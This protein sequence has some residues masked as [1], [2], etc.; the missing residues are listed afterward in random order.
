[1][2]VLSQRYL[3]YLYIPVL[4]FSARNARDDP[5]TCRVKG[6]RGIGEDNATALPR[7]TEVPELKW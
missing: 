2:W 7:L 1:M 3:V 6:S 4:V 5:G